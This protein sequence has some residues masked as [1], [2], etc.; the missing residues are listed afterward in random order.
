MKHV[1]RILTVV[2]V[3]FVLGVVWYAG[4]GEAIVMR[5][6][7]TNAASIPEGTVWVRSDKGLFGGPVTVIA[8][9]LYVASCGKMGLV[10]S[11]MRYPLS[12]RYTTLR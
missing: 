10:V 2:L 11:R 4:A 7:F 3:A 1:G 9:L 12:R 6:V 8:S 5:R